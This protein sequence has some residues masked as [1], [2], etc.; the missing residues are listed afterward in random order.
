MSD[1][2][3]YSGGGTPLPGTPSEEQ[4]HA[5]TSGAKS[6]GK[7]PRFD[8]IPWHYFAARLA[9]RYELGLEK[10]SEDNWKKGLHDPAFILDR[11][12]HMLEHA[13][14]AVER[15]RLYLN[16]YKSPQECMDDDLAA[17]IWGA[18]FLMAAEE[19]RPAAVPPAPP[20]GPI[21]RER[22]MDPG[23]RS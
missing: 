16:N 21:L 6:S 23:W 11:A 10:Y 22:A 19:A 12:N 18:I 8:L 1:R 13:H 17:V 7:L 5:F 2:E 3:R 20:P 14:R 15:L 9:R 4:T